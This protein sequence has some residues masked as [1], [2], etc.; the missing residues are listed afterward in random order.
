MEW[1]ENGMNGMKFV[2]EFLMK[3]FNQ[4]KILSHQEQNL[5]IFCKP[6]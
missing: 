1:N 3:N 2:T 6:L 5:Y 4:K